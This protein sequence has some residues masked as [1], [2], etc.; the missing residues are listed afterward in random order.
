MPLFEGDRSRI[1][2]DQTQATEHPVRLKIMELFTRNT[3]RPLECDVLAADLLTEFPD[4]K[5][6]DVKPAMIAYHVAVLKDAA[7][8]PT[9]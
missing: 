9:R 4:L 3:L 2:A 5:A 7:L 1:T 8:L 6:K